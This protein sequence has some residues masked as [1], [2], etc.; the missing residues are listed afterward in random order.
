MLVRRLA[1]IGLLL[2]APLTACG[3]ETPSVAPVPAA[4]DHP[5][6]SWL[7]R[8]AEAERS[9]AYVGTKRTIH[10]PRGTSRESVMQIERA[11]DGS[12]VVRWN[13]RT[14]RFSDVPLWLDRPE[15]LLANYDVEIDAEAD[16]QI[17]WRPARRLRIVPR[18]DDRPGASV[19]IDEETSVVLRETR[20]ALDGTERLTKVFDQIEFEAP[21]APP[22]DVEM[23]EPRS[24]S[25]GTTSPAHW[26]E[27]TDLPT[28]FEV[29]R[30][31]SLDCGA[32]CAYYSDGLAAFAVMQARV[33]AGTE[34]HGTQA[35]EGASQASFSAIRDGVRVL[36][37]GDLPAELLRRVIEG[38]RTGP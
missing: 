27:P 26:I 11:S 36:V 34:E 21:P 9:T 6:A 1:A 17:A 33:E 13:E 10:G 23:L 12:T 3:P 29:V 18:H 28:G 15:L 20:F 25:L 7:H 19:W 32:S 14:W 2:F 30:R 35:V 37:Q 31:E 4:V 22:A 8:V 38:V 5:A 24:A 16:E